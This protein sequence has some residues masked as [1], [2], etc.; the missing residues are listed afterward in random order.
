MNIIWNRTSRKGIE[1]EDPKNVVNQVATYKYVVIEGQVTVFA[2]ALGK[3]YI[4]RELEE[5]IK[6][7]VLAEIDNDLQQD[8]EVA[9]EVANDVDTKLLSKLPKKVQPSVEGLYKDSEGY[10][11]HLVP[12]HLFVSMDAHT[13]HALT[14]AELKSVC[15]QVNI[16]EV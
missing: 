2:A 11:I 9:N 1:N 12:T 10:W 14:L 5:E 16:K 6:K 8:E 7:R 13:E 15:H 3:K 4:T